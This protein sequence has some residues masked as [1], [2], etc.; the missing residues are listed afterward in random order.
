MS[1]L[2]VLLKGFESISVLAGTV[3]IQAVSAPSCKQ[4]DTSQLAMYTVKVRLIRLYAFR[5]DLLSSSNRISCLLVCNDN[6]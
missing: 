2:D 1:I 4:R 3:S 5:E 6:F